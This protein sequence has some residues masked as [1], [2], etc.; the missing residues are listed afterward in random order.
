MG[1]FGFTTTSAYI[2]SMSFLLDLLFIPSLLR[3]VS[4]NSQL[5]HFLITYSEPFT[6]IVTAS[7]NIILCFMAE[8]KKQ[9]IKI[10]FECEYT[11]QFL[12]SCVRTDTTNIKEAKRL[13][14]LSSLLML[15]TDSHFHTRNDFLFVSR[16][17]SYII[18]IPG[19][20]AGIAGTSSLI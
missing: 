8:K 19:F 16:K 15:Y 2:D 14:S 9:I 12:N 18:P 6:Y 3:Y 17:I 20:P 5:F 13:I 4:P 11:E 1:C 7:K 10:H